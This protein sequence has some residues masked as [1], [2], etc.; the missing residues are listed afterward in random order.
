MARISVARTLH[1]LG[2]A[3]WCGGSLMGAIGLNGAAAT[4]DD[5]RQRG[6]AVNA[7]WTRWAPVNA[8]AIGAHLLGG[9]LIVRENRG[10]IA[11]QQG[12]AAWTTGKTL[13]TGAA[14]G[15]TAA[16]GVYGSKVWKEGDVPV[17]GGT[18]ASGQTPPA[19]AAALPKLKAL[20]WAVPALTGAIIASS[21]TMGEQQRPAEVIKGSAKRAAKAA[22]QAAKH[23][24]ATAK[25]GLA[26][27]QH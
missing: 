22:K 26:L 12:V 6:R 16:A 15:A 24:Q 23:P 17:A 4:L 2:L 9:V 3:V 5:P 27:L 25:T 7:G 20:Q 8:A 14:L 1:D 13:L 10:R 19:A 21:A 11:G 18:E